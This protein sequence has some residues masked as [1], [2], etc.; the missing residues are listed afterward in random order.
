MGVKVLHV[1]DQKGGA[2]TLEDRPE[3]QLLKT[4]RALHPYEHSAP[5]GIANIALSN[6]APDARRARRVNFPETLR[7]GMRSALGE[8]LV[9]GL[10]GHALDLV[11]PAGIEIA[12]GNT[13]ASTISC[14]SI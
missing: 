13:E 7:R 10:A 8:R 2:P 4:K 14:A 9:A 12:S 6:P 3:R 11:E 1:H 5:P